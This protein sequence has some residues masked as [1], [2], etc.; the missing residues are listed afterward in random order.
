MKIA[1]KKIAVTND[2]LTN[3]N[4]VLIAIE[5]AANVNA[6][7]LLTPEGCLS[8]YTSKFDQKEVDD[9]LA[10]ILQAAKNS[11]LG[12]ALGTCFYE[13]PPLSKIPSIPS[14]KGDSGSKKK[15]PFEGG[16]RG[17]FFI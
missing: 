9:A 4:N 13:S 14:G 5:Q 2:V 6:E 1:G 7:I 16:F 17:M 3:K 11:N 15:S 8:G 12:L 10:E